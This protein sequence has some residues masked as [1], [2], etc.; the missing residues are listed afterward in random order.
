MLA[1]Q[2]PQQP[3]AWRGPHTAQVGPRQHAL[4]PAAA[5]T[6]A[7]TTN[8]VAAGPSGTRALR[9]DAAGTDAVVVADPVGVTHVAVYLIEPDDMLRRSVAALL[10]DQP[11]LRLAGQAPRPGHRGGLPP[12]DHHHPHQHPHPSP[13]DAPSGVVLAHTN[14][15]E[16][17]SIIAARAIL[18]TNPQLR[19]LA[20]T[21]T[22]D[23][24]TGLLTALLAGADGH[25]THHTH[26]ETLL[27]TIRAVATGDTLIDAD[28]R[29]QTA[30]RLAGA[31][32]SLA[33]TSTEASVLKLAAAGYLDVQIADRLD[34][35][36]Y[37]VSRHLTATANKLR[38]RYEHIW[39]SDHLTTRHNP[40]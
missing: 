2:Q 23:P 33:L 27:N 13:A 15:T 19:L 8:P 6:A 1:S 32:G 37:Q 9:T 10:A 31:R 35:S 12:T 38:R 22:D 18:S 36:P 4:Q 14:L 29:R 21:A 11:D 5:T 16:T 7:A 30:T 3:Q 25:L 39:L 24:D 34:L 26:P 20:W 17:A 40:L 28:T